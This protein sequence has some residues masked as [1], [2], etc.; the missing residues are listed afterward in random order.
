MVLVFVC[1]YLPVSLTCLKEDREF[2][3]KGIEK[4]EREILQNK[5]DKENKKNEFAKAEK[6][7]QLQS[8][9]FNEVLLFPA[10]VFNADNFISNIER[11]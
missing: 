9:T 3:N 8:Y 6:K 2:R 1:I 5:P 7:I 10:L 11:F 4:K